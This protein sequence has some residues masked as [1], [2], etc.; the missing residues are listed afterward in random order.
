MSRYS[1]YLKSKRP[2]RLWLRSIIFSSLILVCAQ[3]T[4]LAQDLVRTQPKW[5]IGASGALNSNLFYGATQ[6]LS[7]TTTTQGVFHNGDGTGLNGSLLL[8]YRPG[9]VWGG[10]LEVGYDTRNGKF[11][12]VNSPITNYPGSLHSELKYISIEPSLRIAPFS[13][14]FYIF[15]GPTLNFNL[16]NEFTYTQNGNPGS[17]AEGDWSD[18]RKIVISGQVGMGWEIPLVSKYEA[19]QINLSPF[20]SFSPDV[21][22]PR[23]VES[24]DIYTIRVGAALKFGWGDVIEQARAVVA[25]PVIKEGDVQ[26]SLRAPKAVPAKRR[27]RESFPLRDYVFFDQGSTEVQNQY[28]SLT[29]D[30]AASFKEEQLQEVEPMNMTGRS[31]RQ[32][33]VYHN[34]LN[35]V[36]DRMK[37]S[38]STTISL[39]GASESGPAQGKAR[40]ETLKRYLVDIFGI[41]GSRIAT[42]GRNKPRIPSEVPGATKELA[43]VRAGD[44]RVDIMSSSP[45]MMT[46]VGG[47]S[48]FI[49]KPVQIVTVVED[50]LDSRVV[51]TVAGAKEVLASWLLEI[52]DDLGKVQHFGPFTQDQESIS[53]NTILGDRL[54]GEYKVVMLGQTKLGNSLRKEG[55]VTLVRRVPSKEEALRFSILFDFDKSQTVESYEKFLTE[56]VTPLIPN[57]GTVII[58]GYT[59]IVGEEEHN[60]NLSRERVQDARG[61]IERALLGSGKTGITFETFGFGENLQN[62]PFDNKYTEERFY[63]RTVIIDIVP[64]STYAKN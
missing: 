7:A 23:T 27:M 56:V 36:G 22:G 52:T 15:G 21:Q 57:D 37:R 9:R 28:V 8:E 64:P 19:T 41:D 16:W 55:S 48:H 46:Q 10:I 30:Q 5:W 20:I 63:N 1:S 34:I 3:A 50:P 31:L 42:E 39:S 45:E 17:W 47:A 2:T 59:D 6:I 14:A 29:K 62:A 49:L 11:N 44:R 33:A 43:L 53:G 58:H 40:A 61:I 24:W 54:K 4:L 13:S 38:P 35:I 18:I 32:M 60:N 26:F 51:F 12:S 25:P